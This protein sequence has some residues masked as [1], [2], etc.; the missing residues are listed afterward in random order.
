MRLYDNNFAPS[1]RRVR[2]FLAE[3]DLLV[4]LHAVDISTQENTSPEFLKINPLGELPVLEL[5]NGTYL[6]ESLAI[7]RYIEVLYPE[8]CLMGQGTLEKAKIEAIALQL[9]FRIYVPSTHAFRNLHKFWAGRISQVIEYG[10][11]A[12]DEALNE[13]Q[14]MNDLLA[15]QTFMAGEH[16][17]YA[18]IIAFTTLEFGKPSGIRVQPN[19]V[20]LTRWYNT[21]AARPSAKA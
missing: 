11:L 3:K 4:T 19:Q 14:R 17:S 13:W 15:T 16:F 5:D 9:M 1:P 20:N 21:V 10:K 8:P 7:C 2:M 12:R 18:D 6:T